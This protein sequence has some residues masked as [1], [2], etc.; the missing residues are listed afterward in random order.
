MFLA[1]VFTISVDASMAASLKI[2][3][4]YDE[5][6]KEPYIQSGELLVCQP[7]SAGNV[8][9]ADLRLSWRQSAPEI[10]LIQIE[11]SKYVNMTSIFFDIDGTITEY[12]ANSPT[13]FDYDES[14]SVFG[15]RLGKKSS[16]VFAVQLSSLKAV[17]AVKFA[18]GRDGIGEKRRGSNYWRQLLNGLRL[19]S[20]GQLRK[21]ITGR[22]IARIRCIRG[23]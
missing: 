10:V 13:D 22:Q 6:T 14:P 4:E 12:G 3:T 5:I 17:T 7:R 1:I 21:V 11:I 19:L 16:N 2:S 23:K 20:K 9:C 8:P 18:E 15:Y